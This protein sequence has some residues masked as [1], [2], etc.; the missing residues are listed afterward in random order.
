VV[1]PLFK[2]GDKTE[3][4]NYRPLS[5][6]SS[7]YKILEKVMFNQLQNH[8]NNYRILAEEQ[9]GFISNFTTNY[10][11]YKLVNESLI[12]LNNKLMVGGIFFDLKKAFHCLNYDILLSKLEF[13]GVHG[14]AKS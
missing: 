2:K 8:L 7:F 1:K 14:K 12:A 9:F 4:S 11:I 10:A 5:I 3:I 13:Y 6:L